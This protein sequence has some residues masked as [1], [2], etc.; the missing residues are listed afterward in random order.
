M[1]K[2]VKSFFSSLLRPDEFIACAG[3]F[4]EI[5]SRNGPKDPYVT[6]KLQDIMN[7]SLSLEATVQAKKTAL[8]TDD[9]TAKDEA[10]NEAFCSLYSCIDGSCGITMRPDIKTAADYLM[11]KIKLPGNRIDRIGNTKKTGAI[12]RI[13][14]SFKNPDAQS[15][16]NLL[17]ISDLVTAL[18]NAQTAYETAYQT[19]VTAEGKTVSVSDT[20]TECNEVGYHIN[21]LFNYIDG[22]A[23]KDPA[24]FANLVSELNVAISDVM[25]LAHRRRTRAKDSNGKASSESNPTAVTTNN[26]AVKAG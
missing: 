17:Q 8:F 22:Q 3:R 26:E 16:I 21:Q 23:Q 10:R 4:C 24:A 20:K 9:L 6:G 14:E 18:T 7:S 25:A 13:L 11:E 15:Y 19:K 2:D 1:N 12:M 5:V